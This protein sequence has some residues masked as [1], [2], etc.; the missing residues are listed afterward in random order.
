MGFTISGGRVV[1]IDVVTELGR[2]AQLRLD[3]AS[4]GSTPRM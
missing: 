4:L 2:L 3:L 1:E